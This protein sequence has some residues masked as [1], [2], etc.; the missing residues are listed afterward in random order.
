MRRALLLIASSVSI[1]SAAFAQSEAALRAAFEG[2]LIS[3]KVGMPGTSRG[4]DVYPLEPAPVDWREVAERVKD[5]GTAL[6]IG[7][8]VMITKVVVKKNSH[9]EFQ[10]GGGG[11]GTFFDDAGTS[12]VSVTT[13]GESQAE[14]DL[15]KA[16]KEAQGPTRRKE[17]ERELRTV[18]DRRERENARARAD[19]QQANAA[20]EAN[21]RA[22]RAEAGSR[23]NI[24]FKNGIPQESLT[25]E[26]VKAALAQF[27]DFDAGGS[28]V[29]TASG[30]STATPMTSSSTAGAKHAQLK[31]GLTVKEVEE[32]L[33]PADSAGEEKQGALTLNKRS[34]TSDGMKVSTSFLNGVLIDFAITPR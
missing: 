17:L 20:H 26:G 4:I 21:V 6:K 11:W 28:K 3:V 24:R 7:D 2:K 10:L 13:E 29:A 33:G 1:S 16:I 25:P 27:V 23:F 31:K 32:L 30:A 15:K 34:Y 12:N 8:Q 9:I 18:R 19:A 14:K 22:K 5:N